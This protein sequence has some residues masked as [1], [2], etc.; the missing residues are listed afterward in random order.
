LRKYWGTAWTDFI[1][2]RMGPAA[3]V[4]SFPN[5]TSHRNRLLLF[6]KHLAIV[7]WQGSTE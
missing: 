7:C 1:L 2:L 6:V 4:R 5:I 3:G